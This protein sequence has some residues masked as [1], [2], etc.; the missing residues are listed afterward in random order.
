MMVSIIMPM[1]NSAD[2]L[3]DSVDSIIAQD[4]QL[5]EL[6][7]VDD[8]SSDDSLAIA[9]AFAEKDLDEDVALLNAR[10]AK[11]LQV[12]NYDFL[13]EQIKHWVPATAS[14]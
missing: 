3:A 5:W 4:Y 8:H 11:I 6:V 14:D 1:Y 10:L 7:I 9:N 12:E 13:N 2:T